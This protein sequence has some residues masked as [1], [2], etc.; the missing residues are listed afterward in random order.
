MNYQT[1]EP[2]HDLTMIVKCYWILE[3]ALDEAIEKQSIVPDGCMEMVFHYGDPYRQYTPNGHSITQPSCFV[4]GQLTRPLEIEATGKTGIFSVR[5]H[6]NGF[7]PLTNITIKEMEDTAIPLEELFG[8]DGL[9]IEEKILSAHS[10]PEKIKLIEAFLIK[11]LTNAEIIDQVVRSTVETILTA[12]GQLPVEELSRQTNINRRQLERKFSSCIG[13]SPKQ[14]SKTIRLQ[15]ALKM[16]LVN[17]FTNLTSLAYEN[18]Y[19]DQAHFIKDF[20]EFVGITPK[21]FYGKG[22]KMTSFFI[23]D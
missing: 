18:G 8:K 13:L 11:R 14:L 16:L 15:A 17:E 3:S 9:H 2:C 10:A 23:R 22:L 1:F 21:E 19:Y 6:P 20:R 4:I 12:N 7:L 5:F